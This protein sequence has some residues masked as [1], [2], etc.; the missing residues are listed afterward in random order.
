[1]SW[2]PLVL[3]KGCVNI[4]LAEFTQPLIR[5]T[6]PKLQENLSLEHSVVGRIE[7]VNHRF[8]PL[9]VIRNMKRT[10]ASLIG[11]AVAADSMLS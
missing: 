9:E 8:L 10:A 6:W 3:S 5:I 2:V 1:M 4:T 7:N 11:R